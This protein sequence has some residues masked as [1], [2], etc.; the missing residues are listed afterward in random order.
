MTIRK[1]QMSEVR[2]GDRV[3]LRRSGFRTVS[4]VIVSYTAAGADSVIVRFTDSRS[5]YEDWRGYPADMP[6]YVKS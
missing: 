3:S 1:F 6:V 2:V 4:D 5:Q